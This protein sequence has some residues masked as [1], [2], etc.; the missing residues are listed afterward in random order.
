MQRRQRLL[1]IPQGAQ[2]SPTL[3]VIEFSVTILI[4]SFKQF[5]SGWPP[6]LTAWAFT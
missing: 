6:P 5:F 4:E 3:V 1:G 2:C